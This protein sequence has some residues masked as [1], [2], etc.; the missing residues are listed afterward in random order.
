MENFDGNSFRL[1][2]HIHVRL[3]K[4]YPLRSSSF[5]LTFNISFVKVICKFAFRSI[6]GTLLM[7]TRSN[8]TYIIYCTLSVLANKAHR[9][10]YDTCTGITAHTFIIIE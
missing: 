4:Y 3:D 2:M 9:I 1:G 5:T 10:T 6:K 8:F 7:I